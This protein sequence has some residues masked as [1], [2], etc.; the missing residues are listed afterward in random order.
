MAPGTAPKAARAHAL[1]AANVTSKATSAQ[2][3]YNLARVGAGGQP[4][5]SNPNAHTTA[6]LVPTEDPTPSEPPEANGSPEL[7]YTSMSQSDYADPKELAG[8]PY[9]DGRIRNPVPSK[10]KGKTSNSSGSFGVMHMDIKGKDLATDRDAAAKRTSENT[11]LAAK[12]AYQS[13]YQPH[14]KSNWMRIPEETPE[15][16]VPFTGTTPYD[17]ALYG[18][19]QPASNPPRETTVTPVAPAT[20]AAPTAPMVP[21]AQEG[22]GTATYEI[23]PLTPGETKEQQARLLTLLRTL[24]PV[25]VVDQLCK[26][27]A[28]FG[29]V[30][31]APPPQD[32]KFPESAEANGSGA[33]FVGWVAEIFPDLDAQGR[34][35]TRAPRVVEHPVAPV[36]PAAAATATPPVQ[37][38]EKRGRGRPKG[39][40]ASKFRSDKGVKKGPKKSSAGEGVETNGGENDDS[41]VDADDTAIG[42]QE[43]VLTGEQARQNPPAPQT[44]PAEAEVTSSAR[45]RGRPKG[46][47]GKPK[48][49]NPVTENGSS[50]NLQPLSALFSLGKKASR[51]KG[52]KP[53]PKEGAGNPSASTAAAGTT[54]MLATNAQNAAVPEPQQQG[55]PEFALAA[56]QA[57]NESH[58]VDAGQQQPGS[59]QAVNNSAPSVPAAPG[60]QPKAKKANASKSGEKAQPAKKRKR[61]AKDSDATHNQAL[62]GSVQATSD[63]APPSNAAPISVNGNGVHESAIAEPTL[64]APPAP[65]RQRKSKAKSLANAAAK[66]APVAD[67]NAAA[68]STPQVSHTPVPPVQAAQPPADAQGYTSP[69]IEEL[70]AQLDEHEE[71]NFRAPEITTMRAPTRQAHSSQSDQAQALAQPQAQPQLPQRPTQQAQPQQVQQ[72]K[73]VNSGQAMG[74][75]QQ[76]QAAMARQRQQYHQQQQQQAQQQAQQ[77]S[78][79]RTAS[80]SVNNI[81][82]ASPHLSVQS[83]SPNLN[84]AHSVSP[85]LHQQRVSN[86]QTPTSVASQVQSQQARNSQAYYTQQNPSTQSQYGQQQ[87]QQYATAQPK[88]QYNLQ[89]SQQQSYSTQ[90]PSQQ[91]QSFSAQQTQPQYAQQKQQSYAAQQPQQQYGQESQQYST[92]Q[93]V[94]QPQYTATSTATPSQT[95]AS[96]SPQYG[97]SATPAYNSNDGAFRASSSTGLSFATSAYGTSQSSNTPRSNNLYQSPAT[98]TYS[99]PNQQTSSYATSRRPQSTSAS[100]Q[101]PVQNVQSLPQNIGGFS[102][103]GGLGFDMAGLDNSAASHNSLGLN[104]APYNMSAANVSGRSSAGATNFSSMNSFDS[105]IRN[106]A[107]SGYGLPGRR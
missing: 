101:T 86:S 43:V 4:V 11:A 79:A 13:G 29:G 81:P 51:P 85:S 54:Q 95:M 102:D 12:M 32:G 49:G 38:V 28:Y 39:S 78:G 61:N 47:K 91:P 7:Q 55:E 64:T 100:Q 16:G 89:Q 17:H 80:P 98:N 107:Y 36:T 53:R 65:K 58:A 19:K 37:T 66:A 44:I 42:D 106:D 62:P 67:Q 23:Q 34:R 31:E 103:F 104:P 14:R 99:S 96:Q 59:F 52:S 26:A 74:D 1:S 76:R 84:P 27:L 35:K 46:S 33:V 3:A 94:Q 70:T 92:Q 105:T 48:D 50:N 24:Q 72:P 45:K 41:W 57:F 68:S 63:E 30:P 22:G 20:S 83:V 75:Q 93:R 8:Q 10:L 82:T 77:Q 40:K 18:L 90:S 21:V 56:L 97:A 71:Q 87:A 88:Q 9:K 69:T 6:Q 15:P 73:A 2:A 60:V 25:A 5:L